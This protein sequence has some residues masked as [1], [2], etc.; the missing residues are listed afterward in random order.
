V[1][2]S[3]VQDEEEPGDFDALLGRTKAGSMHDDTLPKR[4][5]C[6]SCNV[7]SNVA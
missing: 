4:M 2:R 6:L 5:A 3:L 7:D 1:L